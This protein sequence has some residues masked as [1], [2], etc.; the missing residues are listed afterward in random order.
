MQLMIYL[1]FRQASLYAHHVA[2]WSTF[3]DQMYAIP[4][5]ELLYMG[6]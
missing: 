4:L 3:D 6:I 1:L 5:T 2:M